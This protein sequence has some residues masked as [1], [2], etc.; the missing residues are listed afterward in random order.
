MQKMH[1][2]YENWTEINLQ[3]LIAAIAWVFFFYW[4]KFTRSIDCQNPLFPWTAPCVCLKPPEPLV[5]A[6]DQIHPL[7]PHP[8]TTTFKY[9]KR[10]RGRRQGGGRLRDFIRQPRLFCWEHACRLHAVV[11]T[12]VVGGGGKGGGGG[13]GGGDTLPPESPPVPLRGCAPLTAHVVWEPVCLLLHSHTLELLGFFGDQY[14]LIF[15]GVLQVRLCCC[16]FVCFNDD[17][18]RRRSAGLNATDSKWI[19]VHQ[20]LHHFR[21]WLLVC[22]ID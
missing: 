5:M 16:L 9:V 11:V 20:M 18:I 3:S 4:C 14:S 1:F 19:M 6:T 2:N 13:G 8:A 17:G 7:L 15:T 21:F 22:I 12:E 10:L